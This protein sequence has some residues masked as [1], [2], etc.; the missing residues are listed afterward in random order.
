MSTTK[1]KLELSHLN[2]FLDTIKL[3]NPELKDFVLAGSD[4]R[5]G[6]KVALAKT[7]DY[8]SIS[9]KTDYLTYS[10]MNALLR[11]YMLKS[12]NRFNK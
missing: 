4:S 6:E 9:T 12:E 10:E 7:G 5:I 2:N 1:N 11:G 8:G 3:T